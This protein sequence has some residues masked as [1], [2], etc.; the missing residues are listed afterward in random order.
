MFDHTHHLCANK[1]GV[2][3]FLKA[4][5]AEKKSPS[6]AAELAGN[7]FSCGHITSGRRAVA[8]CFL[9]QPGTT[10]SCCDLEMT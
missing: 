9:S 3:E 2:H 6:V 8:P 7:F 5:V 1:F 4:L 10:V